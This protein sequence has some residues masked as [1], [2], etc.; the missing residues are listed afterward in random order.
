M[1]ERDEENPLERIAA[2]ASVEKLAP[3]GVFGYAAGKSIIAKKLVKH[4]PA[5]KAYTEPFCGSAAMFFTKSKSDVEVLNDIDKEVAFAHRAIKSLSKSELAE[6]DRKNW[7]GSAEQ[8]ARVKKSQ[9]TTKVDRLYKFLYLINFSYG[10]G[11]K[12][13]NPGAAG[14]TSGAAKRVAKFQPR[15]KGVT[16]LNGH[17]DQASKNYDGPD[18][19]HFF[20]PPYAGYKAGG[21][22][23][24]EKD[25]NEAEFR[26]HLEGLKGKFLV[27]YGVKGKLD[28]SG[29][30]V[31]RMRQP[32]TI[33]TMRGVG[34]DQ[35]LTHLLISNYKIQAKSLGDGI[36]LAD[37][38]QIIDV[39]DG[40][41]RIM[42]M[43]SRTSVSVPDQLSPRASKGATPLLSYPDGPVAGRAQLRFMEK[44]VEMD[45]AFDVAGETIAWSLDVQRA[46][47]AGEPSDAAKLFSVDGSRYFSPLT[48]GVPAREMPEHAIAT[49]LVKIDAPQVEL[50]V[51][52]ESI[53]EYF[54]SK[55][56]ELVGQLVL[57][58]APLAERYPWLATLTTSNFVPNAVLKGAALPPDGVSALP[59]SL[60]RVVPADMR[61]W[62]KRGADAQLAHAALVASEFFAAENVAMVDG[63]PTRVLSKLFV[64][65]PEPPAPTSQDWLV[66]KA[67]ELAGDRDVVEVFGAVAGDLPASSV[68]FVD[69]GEF[70][71]GTVEALAK[72]LP[73]QARDY[74]VT[75]VDSPLARAQL[76]KLGRVFRYRP[77]DGAGVDAARRVFA[78]SL[79]VRGGVAWADDVRKGVD[80]SAD[81]LR[82]RVA[83]AVDLAYPPVGGGSGCAPCGNWIV[84]LFDDYAVFSRGDGTLCRVDYAV[85]PDTTVTLTSAPVAVVRAYK[86]IEKTKKFDARRALEH[87]GPPNQW[88]GAI[89][90]LLGPERR[91][92]M[93]AAWDALS[94][95]DREKVHSA[96]ERNFASKAEWTTAYVN[97]LPDSAFLYV[98]PGGEKDDGG[99]TKPRSLRHFP[100]KDKDGAVDVPHLRDAIGRIPQSTAVGAD[101]KDALQARARRAL[102]DTEKALVAK[103]IY[104]AEAD[105][106]SGA[107]ATEP[108]DDTPDLGKGDL[109]A[110]FAGQLV[111][112]VGFGEQTSGVAED[113]R[114]RKADG[115]IEPGSF[116]S[117]EG[118][119]MGRV[120]SRKGNE[121]VVEVWSPINTGDDTGPHWRPTGKT[122]Q[123]SVDALR[124]VADP[125][126]AKR[127][128]RIL[129]AEDG[130]GEDEHFILG[131]VLEPEVVDAQNDIYSDAEVRLAAHRYMEEFQNVGFMHKQI[132][133]SKAQVLESYLAPCDFKIGSQAVKKGTWVMG[134]R[135][136]D[137]ALWKQCKDGGITGFSIG[138]SAQRR[139]DPAADKKYKARKGSTKKKVDF[140]GLPISIDRPKGFVQ[141]GQDE[142]GN[143][144]TREYKFDYGFIPRTKGGDGEG[145]DVYVGP[146]EDAPNAYWI[147]QRKADG[148]FDEYK[149]MVGFD[150]AAAAKKAYLDHTPARFFG[151]MR[152]TSIGQM[153][154]LLNREPEEPLRKSLGSVGVVVDSPA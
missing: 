136:K 123:R 105:E 146:N 24:G 72:S 70:A 3:A 147:V 125:P 109:V 101:Q 35:Y 132:I 74:V 137:A 100:F 102:E 27:T 118:A 28:T 89:A 143:P 4:F 75:A 87:A 12:S 14:A 51:Q 73:V 26:K 44:S 139:P 122:V 65:E 97:E 135:V 60:E 154:A 10:K 33:R 16:I 124:A 80:L 151:G 141:S 6:L 68:A 140:Q 52:T 92:A 48:K 77:G 115:A 15:Y 145:L 134:V 30:E 96:F 103:A 59:V 9:P 99:K 120:L 88:S 117:L 108:S 18:S 110:P 41:D 116:V 138:G 78:T 153:K 106:D 58:R 7:E 150:T 71:D 104:S 54:V 17:Y 43:G 86:P 85:A 38:A 25:F 53:H 55:G 126:I 130:A 39:D 152:E 36:E 1:G 11:R 76:A 67:R 37:V 82:A 8:F 57:Q 47:I 63:E 29:F 34:G 133:N 95:E 111:P 21:G 20:D 31:K 69:A 66:A 84:D 128:F 81:D 98:E 45:L 91:K 112:S 129:K 19:F 46:A 5:H 121:A 32:R 22:G 107:D 64:Y 142:K 42:V 2:A 23:V 119:D 90:G 131:I 148:S 114:R 49:S 62:E 61:Y 50:G 13:F 79:P 83:R 94:K 40:G 144:W 113:R 56:E 127:E 93:Q 149:V